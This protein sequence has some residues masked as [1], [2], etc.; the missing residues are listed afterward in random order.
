[1]VDDGFLFTYS[2]LGFKF[3]GKCVG[4]YAI[5]PIDPGL[6]MDGGEGKIPIAF[7]LRLTFWQFFMGI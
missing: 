6:F 4:K 3:S 1:M 2:F 5:H 7:H